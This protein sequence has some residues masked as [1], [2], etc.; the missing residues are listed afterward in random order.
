MRAAEQRAAKLAAE[1]EEDQL[2]F[3][4]AE[5]R[6]AAEV[7]NLGA[8]KL[9]TKWSVMQTRASALDVAEREILKVDEA[10]VLG[11]LPPLKDDVAQRLAFAVQGLT[12]PPEDAPEVDAYVDGSVH[13][14]MLALLLVIE[15]QLGRACSLRRFYQQELERSE[16]E[17]RVPKNE[18]DFTYT[19]FCEAEVTLLSALLCIELKTRLT[20]NKSK[21]VLVAEGLVQSFRYGTVLVQ[22]KRRRFPDAERWEAMVVFSNLEHLHAI[23][24]VLTEEDFV[25]Y[26]TDP[27]PL[28]APASAPQTSAIPQLAPG[29]EV[30]ARMLCAKPE[31]LGGMFS[32]PPV[33]LRVP[34]IAPRTGDLDVEMG[35]WL[36][37]GGYCDVFQAACRGDAVAVKLPRTPNNA[38]ARFLLRREAAALRKLAKQPSPH[39]PALLGAAIGR[40]APQPTLVM[41]PVGVDAT[42][43]PGAASPP[44]SAARR[45]LADACAEGVFAALR[46]A[47]AEDMLHTDV[48][49]TNVL[50]DELRHVAVLIDWG[51]ARSVPQTLLALQPAALGWPD[52]APDEALR[53]DAGGGPWMPSA[54]GDCESAVYALAALAFGEPCGE[55]PWASDVF[56]DAALQAVAAAAGSPPAPASAR[57]AVAAAVAAARLG[58]RDAWFA[59][60]PPSHPL[61][62]ARMAAQAAQAVFSD[63][64]YALGRGWSVC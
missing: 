35:K 64:P 56:Q 16:P 8:A 21:A 22:A 48:R 61:R 33:R 19:Y 40:D 47:H 44:G 17:K 51:I 15:A 42:R 27:L 54:G 23:R 25:A 12:L 62:V 7:K 24:V 26:T 18:P 1:R 50:W 31:Q 57:S 29:V 63:P 45:A 41:Q 13:S 3:A 6:F 9:A 52:C 59:V 14:R 34:A 4:Q 55:A 5:A 60:L 39:V 11:D 46:A 32:S 30:L 58:A 28:L 10:A 38:Q 53:A 36:G 2:R 49:P 37:S 43:A 20:K